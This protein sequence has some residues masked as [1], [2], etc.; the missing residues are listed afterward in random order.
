[1]G[2]DLGAFWWYN[3]LYVYT[4][5]TVLIATRLLPAILGEVSEEAVLLA[6]RQALEILDEYSHISSLIRNKF[7]RMCEN[8]KPHGR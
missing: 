6:W 8:P 1:M 4:S 3:F 7:K 5:A 2:I